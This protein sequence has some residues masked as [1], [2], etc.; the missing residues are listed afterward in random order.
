MGITENE[1]ALGRKQQ[2][3]KRERYW[4]KQIKN[5]VCPSQGEMHHLNQTVTSVAHY[6]TPLTLS[7]IESRI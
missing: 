2:V 4:E 3:Y 7:L 6:G 1:A 5:C